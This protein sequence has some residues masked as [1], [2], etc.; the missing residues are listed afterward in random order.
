MKRFRFP[1]QPVAV[2]RAHR[3]LRAREAFAAAIQAAARA[4]ADLAT[5]RARVAQFEKALSSGRQENFSALEEAQALTAY[6]A[7]C[8]AE[9]EAERLAREAHAAVQQRRLD[10]IAAHR[11]V[12]VVKRLETKARAA[13]RAAVQ[14]EEQAEFDDF[15]GRSFAAKARAHA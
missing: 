1:L 9:K 14:H 2:L 12:E 5:A 8:A 15:A 6:R 11:N 7:E 4:D 3:E 10:Y 13:H